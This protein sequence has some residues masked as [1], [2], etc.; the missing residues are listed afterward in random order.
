MKQ[1]LIG[2]EKALKLTLENIQPLESE[3][4]PLTE[5]ANRVTAKELRS[6][7]NSPSVDAS[8]KD[9]YAIHSQEI[10]RGKYQKII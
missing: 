8:L 5:S 3:I 1:K 7:V 6:L 2:H 4:I 10:D 9:G